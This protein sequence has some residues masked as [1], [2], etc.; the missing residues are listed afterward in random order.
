MKEL[1]RLMYIWNYKFT[2]EETKKVERGNVSLV[3]V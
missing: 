2:R 3:Y 1:K